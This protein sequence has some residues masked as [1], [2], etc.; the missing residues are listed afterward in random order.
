MDFEVTGTRKKK[1][2]DI[3]AEIE[4]AILINN[5]KLTQIKRIFHR[6][7]VYLFIN[8]QLKCL[9]SK[10]LLKKLINY[11]QQFSQ[12]TFKCFFLNFSRRTTE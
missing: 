1:K 2:N 12:I 4:K 5:L 11:L 10:N 8:V 7:L 6:K 9:I 3:N